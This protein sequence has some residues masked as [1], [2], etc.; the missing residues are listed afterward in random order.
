M[1]LVNK[2]SP[3]TSANARNAD[4]AHALTEYITPMQ[5]MKTMSA[6][7]VQGI[8]ALLYSKLG[9]GKLCTCQTRNVTVSKLS[10]DGKASPG[11]INRLILGN[12]NFG[13]SDYNPSL[14]EVAGDD[15]FDLETSPLNT[16]NPYRGDF[17]KVGHGD[18]S[19]DSN[20]AEIDPEFGDNGQFSPDLEDMFKDFDLSHLGISDVSCPICFGTG[21]VGGYST[22]RSWRKVLVPS[23]LYTISFL[24]LPEMRLSPGTHQV[25]IVLPLGA[26]ILDVWR[27]MNGS[28]ATLSTFYLDG[29]DL[30]NKRILDYCDGKPHT[31]EIVTKEPLT[32]IELQIGLS[33]E[34][35]Y[36]EFPRLPRNADI[37]L[38]EQED[39]FQI[40][41][42]PDVPNLQSL[43]IIAESQQGKILIVQSVNPWNTRNRQMLGWECQVR[44]A[45]PQELWKILPFRRHITGQ[46]VANE[47]RL[48]KSKLIS[49]T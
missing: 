31:L 33:K 28:K 22:F 39:P 14:P 18:N 36:F 25:Q 12:D 6:F 44:V 41:V 38:L 47:A 20:I 23:D 40:I 24:E 19:Q 16:N 9:N 32:H 2:R 35:I 29:M 13:I 30:T 27:T 45:Q 49:G 1:P 48:A 10:E 37:S 15:P 4:V 42:S 34:P 11:A 8:Q 46:K 3:L 26:C 43:D 5:Q 17:N 21:Y 7:R